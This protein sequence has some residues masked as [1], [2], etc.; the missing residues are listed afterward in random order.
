MKITRRS[1]V[2]GT[3]EDKAVVNEMAP[4]FTVKDVDGKTVTLNDLKGEVLLISVFPDI[5]TRVC[6]LQTRRF[7]MEADKH[8]DVKILNLSNNK[9][10]ELSDWCATEGV[11]ALMLSDEDL[12][13]AKAYGLYIA[14]TDVLARSTF[15]IDKDGT[16]VY[17]E[18]ISEITNEPNYDAVFK[19]ASQL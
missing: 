5:N 19:K 2:V 1:D 18:V 8:K 7:F 11:D 17:K 4:A 16:L 12:D 6:D 3:I 15:L 9:P 14:E 10:K 13:F